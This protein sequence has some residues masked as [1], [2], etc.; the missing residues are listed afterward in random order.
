[1]TFEINNFIGAQ[2]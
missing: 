1:V 2:V